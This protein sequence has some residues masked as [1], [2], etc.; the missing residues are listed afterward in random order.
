MAE[1]LKSEHVG[2]TIAPLP[3]PPLESMVQGLSSDMNYTRD[4]RRGGPRA[5]EGGYALRE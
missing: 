2:W 5:E 1:V 3:L 4:T